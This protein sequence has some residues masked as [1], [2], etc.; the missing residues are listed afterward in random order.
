MSIYEF[1]RELFLT[2]CVKFELIASF[3]CI[4]CSKIAK[5]KRSFKRWLFIIPV[6]CSIQ[7]S[8]TKQILLKNLSS[9]KIRLSLIILIICLIIVVYFSR[10]GFFVFLQESTVYWIKNKQIVSWSYK[11]KKGSGYL[12]FNLGLTL[13]ASNCKEKFCFWIRIKWKI[14]FIFYWSAYQT[15]L[16]LNFEIFR[17]IFGN[18]CSRWTL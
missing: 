3:K 13:E 18:S 12:V 7:T 8:S 5:L 2:S 10:F 15:M 14:L 16:V 4:K 1:E 9:N 6:N 11:D 17:T